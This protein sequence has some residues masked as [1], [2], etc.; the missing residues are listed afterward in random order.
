ML[1]EK[2]IIWMRKLKGVKMEM[3]LCD[4][5]IKFKKCFPKGYT[6]S[7]EEKKTECPSYRELTV[8]AMF[9]LKRKGGE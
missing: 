9:R 3:K 5:C 6:L 1:N 4:K 2:K 7:E 8:E